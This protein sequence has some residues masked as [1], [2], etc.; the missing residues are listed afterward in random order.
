MNVRSVDPL[1]PSVALGESTE[2]DGAASSSVIVPVPVAVPITAFVG[3]LNRTATVSFGSSVVS[4]RTDTVIVLLV[5]PAE[6]VNVPEGS[7]V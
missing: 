4:P 7:A 3:P 2:S 5:S 1:S 6:N